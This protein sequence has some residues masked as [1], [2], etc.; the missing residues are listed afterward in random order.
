MAAAAAAAGLGL[1]RQRHGFLGDCTGLVC[2]RLL[3]KGTVSGATVFIAYHE[4]A[5]GVP[6]LTTLV[7]PFRA[8]W[9][10]EFFDVSMTVH[11]LGDPDSCCATAPRCSS[12]RRA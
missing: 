2:R 4:L 12:C 8:R 3:C 1:L 7:I 5:P 10:K 9:L 6:G 11:N